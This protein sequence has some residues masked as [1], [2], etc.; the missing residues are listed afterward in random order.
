MKVLQTPYHWNQPA[1]YVAEDDPGTGMPP[2]NR[3]R[4]SLIF[5]PISTAFYV[6]GGH[7][8]KCS[9]VSLPPWCETAVAPWVHDS[10][11]MALTEEA[12]AATPP[13]CSPEAPCGHMILLNSYTAQGDF[14]TPWLI[15]GCRTGSEQSRSCSC[16]WAPFYRPC[17]M[18]LALSLG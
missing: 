2:S 15:Q 5:T 3:H 4:P 11:L 14:P 16:P 17:P 1:F 12:S 13:V 10:G 6:P 9:Q 7:S 8:L 18:V